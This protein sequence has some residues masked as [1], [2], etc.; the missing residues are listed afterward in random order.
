MAEKIGFLQDHLPAFLVESKQL[1]GI[2][3][4]DIHELDNDMCLP[5]GKRSIIFI[6]EDDL[7]KR[8]DL[9]A[10][11]K[12]AEKAR[13]LQSARL[14]PFSTPALSPGRWGMDRH[15]A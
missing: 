2:F 7:K 9:A 11:R 14:A 6:L 1:Y 10:R 3:S 5:I 13:S 8:E 4:E 12:M 15:A